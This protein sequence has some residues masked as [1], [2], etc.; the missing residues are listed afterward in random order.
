MQ[1]ALIWL[2]FDWEQR[3]VHAVSLLKKIRLGL[4]PVERLKEILGDVLLAIPECKDMVEEV[5]KLSVTKDTAPLPL[6]KNHPEF[7]ATRNT[8]TARLYYEDYD[9][10]SD[11]TH[12]FCCQTDRAC[13]KI[14]NFAQLP[15]RS[16]YP[17]EQASDVT[18]LVSNENQL[19]A[20][21]DIRYN[22]QDAEDKQRH[23][24][25]ISENNFFQYIP[26]KNEWCVLPRVPEMVKSLKM[27]HIEEY[28]YMI[29][30]N[31]GGGLIQRFSI[32][33]KS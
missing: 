22:G 25:W 7:F 4:V 32:L 18:L 28:I 33:S 3:K 6:I 21:V 1:A 13:Y 27:L 20:A 5:V 9:F 31:D 10:Y 26:E 16:P 15:I 11:S 12:T 23:Q 24:D 14:N 30:H 19:Y 17:G 8:I 2:K 29:G